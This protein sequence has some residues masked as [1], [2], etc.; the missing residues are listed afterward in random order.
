[1]N[2]FTDLK[3]PEALLC[4]LQKMCYEKPTPIQA[5][6]IPVAM[7]GR[8]LIACAQTGTGKTAAFCLPIAIELLD[9]PQKIALV[10]V[11]TRELANQIDAYWR[12]LTCFLP[13]LRSACIIGG[14]SFLVQNRALSKKP[15]FL[16]ATPGRLLDHLRHRTVNLSNT[17]ILVLDE[18]D[19]MLDMGFAPQLE[20]IL[21][22]LPKKRQTLLFSATWD[23]S[24]HKLAKKYLQN[25]QH[26]SDGTNSQA[27][28]AVEQKVLSTTGDKKKEVLLD[29]LKQ[30]K[31]SVLVFARTKHRTDRLVRYLNSC[32]LDVGRIHGGRTQSQRNSALS[33]FRSGQMRILIATDIAAR[34]IDVQKIAHVINFD[35]PQVAEDYIH[36]I[37]RT[38]RAG[39]S[40]E[41]LS[42]LTPED[43]SHWKEINRLLKRTGSSIPVCQRT[44][45]A[46]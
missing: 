30:R 17:E 28:V 44:K 27:A 11:P 3:L 18:A 29:E 19:R 24:T 41:A 10:L 12:E 39:L 9:K 1:M 34:G 36:R 21:R 35:L 33:A 14:A 7:E 16:I 13:E 15:R 26:I 25:P 2:S 45:I 31:G 8:D 5:K 42:F 32:G 46:V 38:G 40:G 37:G 6:T 23:N 20:G 22:Y 43:K 4:A